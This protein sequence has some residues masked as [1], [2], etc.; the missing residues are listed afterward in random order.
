[1]VGS[2]HSIPRA[3]SSG[4]PRPSVSRAETPG[5]FRSGPWSKT[6][7]KRHRFRSAPERVPFFV[8]KTTIDDL[9]LIVKEKQHE[10]KE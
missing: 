7:L 6:R 4:N 1:M 10:R 3:E 9:E 8:R 5:I 2:F